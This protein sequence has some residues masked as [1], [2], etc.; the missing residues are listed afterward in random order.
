MPTGSYPQGSILQNSYYTYNIQYPLPS[1]VLQN[2]YYT[3]TI[4]V[5]STVEFLLTYPA[6]YSGSVPRE[7]TPTGSSSGSGPCPPVTPPRIVGQLW[8]R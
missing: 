1:P 5:P 2:S 8:P 7:T 3:Y 4:K 6:G